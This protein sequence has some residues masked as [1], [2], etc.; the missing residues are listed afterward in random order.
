M[1]HLHEL[2]NIYE[3]SPLS[4]SYQGPIPLPLVLSTTSH[5]A[6]STPPS[7]T[8]L[9][10]AGVSFSMTLCA[11]SARS[12]RDGLRAIYLAR[13]NRET[14]AGAYSVDTPA[15]FHCV[16]PPGSTRLPPARPG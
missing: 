2:D 8:N 6:Y 14:L 15:C 16:T 5:P 11:A 13:A 3:F 10:A 12:E 4:A 7:R 1:L 9:A